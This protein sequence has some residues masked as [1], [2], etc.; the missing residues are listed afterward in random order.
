[1]EGKLIKLKE[2]FKKQ[3]VNK[4]NRLEK[5][6]ASIIKKIESLK[7]KGEDSSASEKALAKLDAEIIDETSGGSFEFE[8]F[9]PVARMQT[10]SEFEG[11]SSR[12]K[13]L[14]E[15]LSA[16]SKDKD[17]SGG[18]DTRINFG[19]QGMVKQLREE[20]VMTTKIKKKRMT[21]PFKMC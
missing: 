14:S 1:M 20:G 6:K 12:Q 19:M 8:S 11:K 21:N 13:S 9:I 17:E 10:E 16:A 5:K 2:S 18:G 7:K 4:T 3:S 15:A